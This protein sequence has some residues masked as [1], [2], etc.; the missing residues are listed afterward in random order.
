MGSRV[1]SALQPSWEIMNTS[2]GVR[3]T[4]SYLLSYTAGLWAPVL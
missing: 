2:H 1:P 4:S 3:D